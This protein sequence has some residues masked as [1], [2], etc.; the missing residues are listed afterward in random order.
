MLERVDRHQCGIRYFNRRTIR[1]LFAGKHEAGA[2]KVRVSAER[3][4]N[5]TA[6]IVRPIEPHPDDIKWLSGFV[7]RLRERQQ[8]LAI[9]DNFN[10]RTNIAEIA[11]DNFRTQA[12][13]DQGQ[14]PNIV[15]CKRPI[16]CDTLGNI[17]RQR[18]AEL[19]ALAG[20]TGDRDLTFHQIEQPFDDREAKPSATEAPRRRRFR[21]CKGRE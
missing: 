18:D 13:V 19:A 3:F 12:G 5:L 11:F 6:L 9:I 14:N 7:C 16:E 20:L 15:E 2:C 4:A 10:V 17:V 1:A 8:F 21:L